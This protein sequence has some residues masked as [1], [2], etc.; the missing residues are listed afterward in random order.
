M[1]LIPKSINNQQ[2]H[3]KY[4]LKQH[5]TRIVAVVAMLAGIL[6][7]G[8]IFSGIIIPKQ[9]IGSIFESMPVYKTGMGAINGHVI[10]P[11]G[12]PAVDAT[13]VAVQQ[14]GTKKIMMAI[15]PMDGKYVF[16]DLE[17]GNYVLMVGFPNGE[18]RILNYLDVDSGSI[19]TIDFKY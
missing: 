11:A 4:M 2:N 7:I 16:Q 19:H 14:G 12:L 15:I 1:A 13:I 6:I 8:Y 17:P 5:K 3:L 9:S 18:N 10:G